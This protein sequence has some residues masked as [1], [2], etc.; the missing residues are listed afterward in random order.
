MT[1]PGDSSSKRSISIRTRQKRAEKG[2]QTINGVALFVVPRNGPSFQSGRNYL[3]FFSRLD[4]LALLAPEECVREMVLWL[5]G[6]IGLW[7]VLVIRCL[8]VFFCV[9]YGFSVRAK[10]GNEGNEITRS[11]NGIN[12]VDLLIC[13][14][15]RWP[16]HICS[17]TWNSFVSVLC[18]EPKM[19]KKSHS[20]PA[21]DER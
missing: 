3:V 6:F 1:S 19:Q 12:A 10:K 11:Y 15:T 20:T 21:G 17:P 18:G 2:N 4:Y 16:F 7:P 14:D 13:G 9:G 5:P 8:L